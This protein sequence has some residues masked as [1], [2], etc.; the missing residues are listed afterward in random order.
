MTV[1]FASRWGT[2]RVKSL[3]SKI[4]SGKTP[5]GGS[6]SYVSE[7][8]TFLR[9]QNVHFS[10]LR[11]DDVAF[12]T[13]ATH[14]EMWGSRVSA[15]DVL[16][17]ITGASL[18]R[19]T[20]AP[21][22]I[23]EANVNQHVCIIR[24]GQ[25]AHPGYLSYALASRP[26]QEQI[27]ELQVGGNREGLNFEQVGN[28]SVPA[29]PLE[30]QRRIADFLD[31]ETARI[32]R[33]AARYARMAGLVAERRSALIREQL[34]TGEVTAPESRRVPWL[35][36]MP[37]HW[38]AAPLR[39]ISRIQRGA[40][41]RPIDNPDYFEET[42]THAWVRISDVTASGKYLRTSTQ[43]LSPLGVSLSVPLEPGELFVSIAASVGKPVITDIPCCIHDGFVA[44]RNPSVNTDL[45][46]YVL[47]LGDAFKGLGKLG[48]QLNLNSES[49]GSIKVP[50]PPESEQ[51]AIVARLDDGLRSMDDLQ[52]SL[53]RQSH[54]LAERRQALITDAVT[55]RFDVSTADSRNVTDGVQ[56]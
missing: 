49:I 50:V 56:A 21:H 7:G 3:A 35:S 26:G 34:S 54:L 55:G 19:V 29:A 15:G 8:I 5:T 39:Y 6:E 9:S 20:P 51:K 47:L 48:T 2:R 43:R 25:H 44:I 12:I 11:L 14:H 27:F 23:G 1:S 45:L 17:N 22:D 37:E 41:P 18:G 24:P 13:Q 16:L 31:V 28:L 36:H 40:S 52:A 32:D 10:G 4:G 42:G 30:E 53:R 46:Y 33:L 38:G